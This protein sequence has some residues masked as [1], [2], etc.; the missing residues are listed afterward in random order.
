MNLLD[1]R[2]KLKIYNACDVLV[3]F[4]KLGKCVKNINEPS[5]RESKDREKTKKKKSGCVLLTS[6][7]Q[8]ST[9]L[10]VN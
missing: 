5:D 3:I 10:V 7:K 9:N 8:S 2:K 1:A 6:A 4:R